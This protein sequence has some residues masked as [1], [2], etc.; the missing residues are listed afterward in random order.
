MVKAKKNKATAMLTRHQMVAYNQGV[1]K[2]CPI[3]SLFF[4][5]VVKIAAAPW[6]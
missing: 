4:E 1:T 2:W 5:K 3:S 6:Q